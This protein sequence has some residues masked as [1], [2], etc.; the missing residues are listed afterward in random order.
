MGRLV[1]GLRSIGIHGSSWLLTEGKWLA[2]LENCGD[3][4]VGEGNVF[5]KV[6]YWIFTVRTHEYGLGV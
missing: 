4:W 1:G 2:M 6:E 3:L 5:G